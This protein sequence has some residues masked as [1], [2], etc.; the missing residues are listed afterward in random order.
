MHWESYFSI[1]ITLYINYMSI[2]HFHITESH[3]YALVVSSCET[4]SSILPTNDMSNFV[5]IYVLRC[6]FVL[7]L[8]LGGVRF[9]QKS[10]DRSIFSLHMKHENRVV[11][12]KKRFTAIQQI[13]DTTLQ[14]EQNNT[15]ILEHHLWVKICLITIWL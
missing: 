13:S 7:V 15:L 4:K 10:C 5:Y 1:D 8:L 11:S 12:K 2:K 3:Y 6:F 9:S 14:K